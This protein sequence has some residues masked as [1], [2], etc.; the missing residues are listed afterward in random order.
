MG[1]GAGSLFNYRS[2][3]WVGIYLGVELLGRYLTV[4][5]SAG[6]AFNYGSKCWV[7]I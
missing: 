3:C 7:S 5:I 2:K 1:L 6:S 4:G